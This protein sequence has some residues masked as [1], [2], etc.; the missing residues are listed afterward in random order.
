MSAIIV[1]K[2]NESVDDCISIEEKLLKFL[3]KNK[4][5]YV[6]ISDT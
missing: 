5:K 4:V 3:D 6:S 2:I 1:F